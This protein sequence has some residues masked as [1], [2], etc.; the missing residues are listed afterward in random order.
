MAFTSLLLLILIF[1][2]YLFPYI[3]YLSRW[4][5]Q[6]YFFSFIVLIYVHCYLVVVNICWTRLC[7]KVYW[8]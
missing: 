3:S 4:W 8:D 7:R 1:D 6:S 2:A 5:L